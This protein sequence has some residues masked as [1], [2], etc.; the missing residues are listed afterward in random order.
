MRIV[1]TIVIPT[2][3]RAE[4]LMNTLSLWKDQIMRNQEEISLIVCNNASTDKTKEYLDC[5]KQECNFFCIVN[6][7]EHVSIGQSLNRSIENANSKYVMLWGD[8]D[9]PSPFLADICLKYIKNNHEYG[10]IY[11]NRLVGVDVD[12]LQVKKTF[13]LERRY[14]KESDIFDS[15]DQF[16]RMHFCDSTLLSTIIFRKSKW[17]DHKNEIITSKHYGYEHLYQIMASVGTDIILKI[18]YP[19][20]IQRMPILKH[21]SWNVKM[22]L[23]RLLGI[24]NLLFDMERN[25]LISSAK[26]IWNKDANSLKA[27]LI[28][29]LQAA[30]YKKEYKPLIKQI[31]S[32]QFSTF[33]K[34]SVILILY[35]CPS[36]MYALLKSLK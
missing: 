4:I 30:A 21:R 23:Y 26:E 32:Y 14:S 16:L 8:D 11:Y 31:Q 3:N 7:S 27:F 34:L 28:A 19:L 10:L 1:L 13:V 18:N 15:L 6:Y 33:R 12:G 24:P 17:D 36:W 35:L 29:M 9:I 20:C 25:G 2:Y 22:G 5:L